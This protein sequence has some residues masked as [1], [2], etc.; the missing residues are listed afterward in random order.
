MNVVNQLKYI[1]MRQNKMALG[2]LC[3]ITAVVVYGYLKVNAGAIGFVNGF[4]GVDASEFVSLEGAVLSATQSI[5]KLLMIL[6][7]VLVGTDYRY[8]IG[9]NL[10]MEGLPRL[11]LLQI[12]VMQ[13]LIYMLISFVISLL[14]AL[15]VVAQT[16]L[17][18]ELLAIFFDPS[19]LSRMIIGWF[20][21]SSIALFLVVVTRSIVIGVLS[22]LF[23]GVISIAVKVVLMVTELSAEYA[24]Y[25]PWNTLDTIVE[26]KQPEMPHLMV[27]VLFFVGMYITMVRLISKRDLL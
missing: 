14:A 4:E 21:L 6:T 20:Y 3:L 11:K 10:V 7:A 1:W 16:D 13:I 26:G 2:T 8:G 27:C 19:V 23:T 17:G 5:D 22:F 15:V 9:R 18:S 24:K 25:I 12:W